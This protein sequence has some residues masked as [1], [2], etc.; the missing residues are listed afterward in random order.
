[1]VASFLIP[2]LTCDLSIDSWE[3]KQAE[4]S[5]VMTRKRAS[6]LHKWII[7]RDFFPAGGFYLVKIPDNSI[8]ANSKI[9]AL[10]TYKV[11][12]RGISSVG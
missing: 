2:Y 3:V 5:M 12:L 11:D 10:I 6:N 9:I 7:N 1:M 8:F 4:T